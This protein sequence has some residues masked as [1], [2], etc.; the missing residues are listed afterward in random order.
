MF[1][2]VK[3][4]SPIHLGYKPHV[5]GFLLPSTRMVCGEADNNPREGNKMKPSN[6]SS[7][8]QNANRGTAGTNR[9]YSQNQGNRGVQMNP[10]RGGGNPGKG[11]KK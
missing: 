9:Q 3:N 5:N 2:G 10:N 6:N 1:A 4:V 8:M 7:N 11:G